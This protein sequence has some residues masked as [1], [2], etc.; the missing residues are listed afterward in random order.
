LFDFQ[1]NWDDEED[2]EKDKPIETGLGLFVTN[3]CCIFVL[4]VSTSSR[5]TP[6]GYSDQSAYE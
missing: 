6:F 4:C 3:D 2:K 1:E 5:C